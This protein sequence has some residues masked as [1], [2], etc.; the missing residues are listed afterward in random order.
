MKIK[1]FMLERFFARYE[2]TTPHFL[3]CSDCETFSIKELLDLEESAREEFEKLQ[4][5]YTEYP[6]APY[7]REAVSTL[8]TN[9]QPESIL[10]FSGAE[11]A[12][13]IYMNVLLGKGD[14]IIVQTPCYQ[15]LSEV[16]NAGGCTIK[17]W[18]MTANGK[19]DLDLNYLEDTVDET[20]KAI[21][22]N[23]PHNPTGYSITKGQLNE[24][25]TFARK[26]DLYVF[27]DEVYRFLEYDE[28]KRL[29]S[30]CDIYEKG[31]SLGVMSKAFGLAGLRIGWLGMK[32]V[33]LMERIAA[34]KDYTTLCNSAPSEYLAALAIRH[35]EFI[36]GRN[37]SLVKNNLKLLDDFFARHSD[38]FDWLKPTAGPIAFPCFKN[39]TQAE[40]FCLDLIEKKGVLLLP[41]SLYQWEGAKHF[42]IGFGRKSLPEVLPIFEEYLDGMKLT[43]TV[44]AGM[45]PPAAPPRGVG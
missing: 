13:Y 26:H 5:G 28:D 14:S 38:T 31:V 12:I 10:I 3:C 40:P 35:K 42:R 43:F 30:I 24:I 4:L 11:E 21:V 20:T 44:G 37:L 29:P 27:V 6:G 23:L 25:V 2:F 22:V 39:D 7:L 16:A 1:N 15:S 41:G 45:M 19:W 34:Y 32:D 18:S 17:E 9:T 33:K 36:L 8:Y